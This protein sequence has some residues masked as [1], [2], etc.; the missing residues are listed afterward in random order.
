MDEL[1]G[2][3]VEPSH[4]VRSFSPEHRP[5]ADVLHSSKC[6]VNNCSNPLGQVLI[7]TPLQVLWHGFSPP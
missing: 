4:A 5:E 6:S 7:E 3:A 1:V 2:R